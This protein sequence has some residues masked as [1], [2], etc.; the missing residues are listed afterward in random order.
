MYSRDTTM[1]GFNVLMTCHAIFEGRLKDRLCDAP[2]LP[3][4]RDSGKMAAALCLGIFLKLAGGVGWE[5]E[6][7]M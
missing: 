2:N 6:A 5:P 1:F 3:P 4:R 7:P